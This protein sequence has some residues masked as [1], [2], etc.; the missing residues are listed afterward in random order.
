M[1]VLAQY[2][3]SPQPGRR[4]EA[5]SQMDSTHMFLIYNSIEFVLHAKNE[6]NMHTT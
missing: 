5:P 4:T 6:G 3:L 2:W 1:V